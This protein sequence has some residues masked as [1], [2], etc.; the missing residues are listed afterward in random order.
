MN[1][2]VV[3]SL[4]AS[5][6]FTPFSTGLG[7]ILLYGLGFSPL[8]AAIIS[9]LVLATL[10]MV[11]LL[12]RKLYPAYVRQLTERLLEKALQ[13]NTNDTNKAGLAFRR[14]I[15]GRV[16]QETPEEVHR[17]SAFTTTQQQDALVTE[18]PNQA[19]C[20]Q[21]IRE[22]CRNARTIKILTIRGEK[23]FVGSRSLLRD[24]CLSKRGEGHTISV[25]VLSPDSDHITNELAHDLKHRSAEEIKEKMQ[26]V[27][28]Y[29]KG[30]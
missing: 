9:I 23:Y 19:S 16:L 10:V 29:G 20:E 1:S 18:F 15:I 7:S 4:I 8:D 24:L 25:L 30:I 13:V 22:A 21:A 6:I 28:E 5:A 3:D 26:D 27:L 11:F 12:G 14:K 2:N 17:P